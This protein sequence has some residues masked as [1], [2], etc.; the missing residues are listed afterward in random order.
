MYMFSN[1]LDNKKS[2]TRYPVYAGSWYDANGDRL[3]AQLNTF[4]AQASPIIDRTST[5]VL[6]DEQPDL[7]NPVLAIV[8]PHAGYMFSGQ[9]AA[10]SYKAAAKQEIKRIILLGPSHH[11]G[12]PG[13]ALPE[14]TTFAT[15]VGNLNV[16]L[17]TVY[18]LKDY[19]LFAL[20]PN[21][22]NV[23]H[24]L[25][26]QLP[27]IHQVFGPVKIVPIVV[28]TLK[29]ESEIN[30][31]A[32]ILQRYI[33][34]GDLIIVSSDFTHYGPRYGYNPFVGNV[35]ETVQK[36]DAEAYHYLSKLDLEGF[37]SF[38]ERTK[39]T[40]CGFYPLTLLMA[41]L[42][43]TTKATLLKYWTSQDTKHE[44]KDNSVSYLSIAFS[45]TP[46]KKTTSEDTSA[47]DHISLTHSD[48]TSLLKL[49]RW[50]IESYVRKG[51]APTLDEVELTIT[52]PMQQVLGTFVTLHKHLSPTKIIHSAPIHTSLHHA[53]ELRGCI[54][55][56]W[57]IKPLYQAIMENAVSACS[58]DYRFT[59]VRE[60]ELSDI[61]IEISVL[62][63]PKRI[64][65]YSDIVLGRDGIILLKDGY[66]SVFLPCVPIEF[67]W[68][69]KQTLEQLSHKAGLE[70]SS[71]QAGAKFDVFQT[72]VFEETEHFNE[73]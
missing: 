1:W 5:T 45:G 59:S 50:T 66:Q 40:I 56:I 70:L 43:K 32:K 9:T 53:R 4:L 31:A 26:M 19:P 10:Y 20:R 12:F 18:E 25:E 35:K 38:Q 52:K 27:F 39:D 33:K 29:G 57:P 68:D 15:P 69:L 60:D 21:V 17:E 14:N 62:T 30:L 58:H 36:L 22:H 34:D 44:D 71:W 64:A 47:K 2:D 37:V 54:G 23:E 46:W 48:Q 8:V 42:P 13:L 28:G 73:S 67:G 3:S 61:H 63:P 24:S 72:V 6:I 16:D 7:E 65:S 41:L 55:H 51:K 49:A 11:V